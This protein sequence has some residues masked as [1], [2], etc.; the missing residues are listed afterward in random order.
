MVDLN[1]VK[2]K[3]M[4]ALRDGADPDDPMVA[5]AKR[6]L[7]A[8]SKAKDEGTPGII[9]RLN[10]QINDQERSDKKASVRGIIVI[11][12]SALALICTVITVYVLLWG[13]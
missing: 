5:V 12:L 10:K 1:E 2:K 8:E 4:Q 9:A 11:A 7:E 13:K 3:A 6:R